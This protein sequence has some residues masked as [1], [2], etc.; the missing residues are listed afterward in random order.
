MKW[1]QN[2]FFV[3]IKARVV[4]DDLEL[5]YILIYDIMTK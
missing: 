1:L 4:E 3:K 5:N 2:K